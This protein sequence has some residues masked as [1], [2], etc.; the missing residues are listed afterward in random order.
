MPVADSGSQCELHILDDTFGYTHSVKHSV[1]YTLGYTHS[2]THSVWRAG[3]LKH[4]KNVSK[5]IEHEPE[6][7]RSK[8]L[9]LQGFF[10]PQNNQKDQPDF[11]AKDIC[12]SQ[13]FHLESLLKVKKPNY[14][15]HR[16]DRSTARFAVQTDFKFFELRGPVQLAKGLQEAKGPG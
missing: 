10:R 14:Q 5:L 7:G 11:W 2:L 15:K 16:N 3:W 4:R 6:K 1:Y 8:F 12:E 9:G 13:I